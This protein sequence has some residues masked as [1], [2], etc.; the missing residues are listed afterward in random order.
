MMAQAA[1]NLL[2]RRGKPQA[3]WF[4]HHLEGYRATVAGIG[5]GE[6]SSRP[7]AETL[8]RGVI[9]PRLEETQLGP[10]P[11]EDVAIASGP[12]LLDMAISAAKSMAQFLGSG[13]RT[14]AADVRSERLQVCATCTH[15]TGLRCRL[16]GC[17]T[18]LKAALAH[19]E[20]PVGKWPT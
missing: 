4:T 13:W 17:F 11:A 10:H 7:A 3:A 14:T 6:T 1:V 19:E 8:L 20:C 12:R 9:T 18:D 15:H 16:C 5:M 2:E